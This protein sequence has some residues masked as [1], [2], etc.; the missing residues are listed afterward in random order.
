MEEIWKPIKDYEGLY[1]VSNQGQVKNKHNRILKPEIRNGYYSVNLC[2]NGKM[3]HFRIH[4]LVAITFIPNPKNYPMVNH[5]DENKLNNEASNLEW[6]TNVYNTHYSK[7]EDLSVYCLDL[8]EYFESA[9]NA[10]VHTGVCRTSILKCCR[11]QLQRAG[12]MLWCYSKDKDI[13]FPL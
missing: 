2:K 3:T 12:G 8:D 1:W 4:R 10:A 5:K 11:G 9:S 7:H 13:K 6:C